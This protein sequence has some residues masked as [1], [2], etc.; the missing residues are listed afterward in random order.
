MNPILHST[1]LG[2]GIG[3]VFR[4]VPLGLGY[5]A[6]KRRQGIGGFIGCVIAG[7]FGGLYPAMALMAAFSLQLMQPAPARGDAATEWSG[8][9][10]TADKSWYGL[11]MCLL[12]VCMI[13][14]MF[15]SAAFFTPLTRGL[16]NCAPGDPLG[17]I[18]EPVMLFGGMGLGMAIGCVAFSF[19]SRRC[20]SS[21]T[22]ANW[23][24]RYEEGA[25]QGS[26]LIEKLVAFYYKMM[27]PADWPLVRCRR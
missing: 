16:P 4:L 10:S 12:F 18:V 17:D 25:A 15:V 23:A 6:S 26:A 3:A 20:I 24:S 2:I 9:A 1:L 11:G 22:H 8:L 7:A 5:R 19:I 21:A 14:T 13:G 27:L